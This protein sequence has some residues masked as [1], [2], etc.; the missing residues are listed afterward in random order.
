MKK[1]K[2]IEIKNP[3]ATYFL[4]INISPESEGIC[5]HIKKGKT[6]GLKCTSKKNNVIELNFVEIKI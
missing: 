5:G 4:Q 1:N 3:P 6:Y 2:G